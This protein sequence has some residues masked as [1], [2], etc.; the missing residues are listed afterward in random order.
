M[1]RTFD[2]VEVVLGASALGM[3]IGSMVRVVFR[4]MK[5]LDAKALASLISLM[6][7]AGVIGLFR[8]IA[9]QNLSDDIY[10]V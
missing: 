8:A 3:L 6:V 7:G 2:R 5:K 4:Q 1:Q 10:H 9:G